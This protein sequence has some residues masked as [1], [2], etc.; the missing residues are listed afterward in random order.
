MVSIPSRIT[1]LPRT[2]KVAV[3]IVFLIIS[4]LFFSSASWDTYDRFTLRPFDSS[5]TSGY[6]TSNYPPKPISH[7]DQDKVLVV[8]AFFPLPKSNHQ[9]SDYEAWIS[10]FLSTVKTDIY[11]YTPPNMVSMIRRLRG[12]LP[13]YIN[14]SY[15]SPF[16]VPPMQGLEEDYILMNKS[17]KFSHRAV[18]HH[19]MSAI[20]NSKP[21]FM[22]EAMRHAPDTSLAFGR[23][24]KHYEYV[25]WSDAGGMREPN[26]YE[27]WP[28]YNRVDALW[29]EARKLSGY[30]IQ[31]D[32]F[33]FIP[34]AEMG[35]WGKYKDEGRSWKDVH[36]PANPGQV[37]WSEG[38]FLGG[39][40]SAISWFRE[41]YYTY[42]N[43]WLAEAMFV[44]V[45]QD[46]FSAIMLLYSHRFI[47]VWLTDPEAPARHHTSVPEAAGS[48]DRWSPLGACGAHW[49][50][51]EWFLS[52][53]E[54]RDKMRD[55]WIG[56]IEE[57]QN[58]PVQGNW[59]GW[60]KGSNACRLTNLIWLQ[61]LLKRELGDSWITPEA[62]LANLENPKPK[63][64]KWV[65]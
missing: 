15:S 44:G 60:W 50:Y 6:P 53:G 46:L 24:D 45:D 7:S 43:A 29:E 58:Q 38:S 11:F 9:I 25:F 42:H 35:S 17:S 52:D 64:I 2:V 30:M 39:Q 41:I 26:F 28:E 54:T 13:I 47:T 49:Y 59:D 1:L 56:Q 19:A 10:Y 27:H 48:S 14:S 4:G 40:P 57:P 23:K 36:G 8:S 3:L 32:E 37:P 20:W 55:K 34:I 5:S 21:F 51:Y 22:D 65:P 62:T 61:Q 33:F 16:D 63:N 12:D 18:H 31:K